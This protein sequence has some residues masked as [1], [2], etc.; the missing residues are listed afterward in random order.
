MNQ[1]DPCFTVFT[2]LLILFLYLTFHTLYVIK[3]SITNELQTQMLSC[4]NYDLF[5]LFC[6]FAFIHFW[7]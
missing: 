3:T 6:T 4:T 2:A 5:H 1:N 7:I